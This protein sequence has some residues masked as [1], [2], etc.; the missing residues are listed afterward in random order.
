MNVDNDGDGD[1]ENT[2][3]GL[4]IPGTI[5]NNTVLYSIAWHMVGTE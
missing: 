2:T 3:S 4:P 1:D 5:I